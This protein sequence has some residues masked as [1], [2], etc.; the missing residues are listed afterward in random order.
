MAPTRSHPACARSKFLE[1]CQA[2]SGTI[3]LVVS[4]RFRETSSM[5][6]S[7]IADANGGIN[8][9][10]NPPEEKTS[11]RRK[12]REKEGGRVPPLPAHSPCS[13]TRRWALGAHRHRPPLP[14]TSTSTSPAA[15]LPPAGASWKLCPPQHRRARQHSH[16]HRRRRFPVSLGDRASSSVEAAVGRAAAWPA[17]VRRARPGQM[18]CARARGGRSFSSNG[19]ATP[20]TQRPLLVSSRRR[21]SPPCC[22]CTR[23]AFEVEPTI[24]PRASETTR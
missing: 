10:L 14:P 15:C 6:V 2:V 12:G 4:P 23:A 5:W 24:A 8:L 16:D 7:K 9:L 22:Y 1:V 21:L 11:Q 13:D 20:L 3:Y 18:A 17:S 19:T